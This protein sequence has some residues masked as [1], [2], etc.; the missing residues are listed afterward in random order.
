MVDAPASTWVEV[1]E[2]G[3]YLDASDDALAI[4]GVS[5]D[6]LRLRRVGDFAPRGLGS[7]HRALFLWVARQG[8]DFGGGSSTIVRPDGRSACIQVTSIERRAD[9]YRL[10]LAAGTGAA[11]APHTAA[12]APVLEAW[13]LAERQVAVGEEG[14]DRELAKHAAEALRD[15]YQVVATEK[16]AA[17]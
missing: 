11:T 17:D 13:R 6:E 10:T 7:I 16:S 4:F 5:L 14:P 1:D 9:R 8:N 2:Q 15:V 3:R 12:I